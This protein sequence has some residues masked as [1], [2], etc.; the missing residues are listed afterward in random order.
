M[1]TSDFEYY[2]HLGYISKYYFEQNDQFEFGNSFGEIIKTYPFELSVDSHSI[3]Q[4]LNHHYF[5]GD[6]TL[7]KGLK[8]SPWLSKPSAN[9]DSWESAS[10]PE[11]GKKVL[12]IEEIASSL[13]QKIRSEILK[14]ID[15]KKSIGILLSGGMDS[16]VVAM[17]LEDIRKSNRTDIS[18]VALNWGIENSRDKIYAQQI[19]GMYSWEFKSFELNPALLKEAIYE[20]AQAGAEFSP[21]NVHAM[22]KIRDTAGIDCILA[23]SYGDS[24]GRGEYSKKHVTELKSL[25]KPIINW[26]NLLKRQVIIDAKDALT[27]DVAQYRKKFPRKVEQEHCE[28]ERQC[29]YMRRML[30]PCM[31]IINQKTPVYQ[32]FT[33]P[34]VFGFMWSLDPSIRG[35][36]IY[37]KLFEMYSPSL[38]EIPW[39]RTGLRYGDTSGTPD[40]LLS[41]H[42]EYGKW[43]R[44]ELRSYVN[45]TLNDDCVKSLNLFNK[46][47]IDSLSKHFHRMAS[48][49]K[50]SKVEQFLLWICALGEINRQYDL[51]SPDPKTSVVDRLNGKLVSP[52]LAFGHTKLKGF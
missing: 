41:N 52:L 12:A 20:T 5:L 36:D 16:R 7:I 24:I 21:V 31:G 26:F 28:V 11:H 2:D 18:V 25:E 4:F 43:I 39:A 40:A 35:N 42:N 14:Y 17:I 15:G 27:L 48:G 45:E 50:S 32:I 33:D 49:S 8:K 34:K 22:H 38:L 6:R 10:L 13:Y 19:A 29:H 1:N 47:S 44:T 46:D 30:N 9:N 23:G 3:V 37:E 51:N